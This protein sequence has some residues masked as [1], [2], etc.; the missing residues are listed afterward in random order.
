VW[1]DELGHEA[2]VMKAIESVRNEL[3]RSAQR[4]IG[5]KREPDREQGIVK[6]A[7]CTHHSAPPYIHESLLLH[8][9]N[10]QGILSRLYG[11]VS[12][13]PVQLKTQIRWMILRDMPEVLEAEGDSDVLCIEEYVIRCLRQ[14]NCMGLVAEAQRRVLGFM[15]YELFENY[16]NILNLCVHPDAR[17]RGVGTEMV[18]KLCGKLSEGRNCIL[19]KLRETNLG[20]QIFL[21]GRGFRAISTLHGFYKDTG[22]DAYLMQYKHVSRTRGGVE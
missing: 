2:Y 9:S 21:R 1:G 8:S 22:E 12:P 16:F 17:R 13:L 10:V 11:R 7:Y 4:N 15:L 6:K 3:R 18:G 14:R 20:A 19:L 5:G